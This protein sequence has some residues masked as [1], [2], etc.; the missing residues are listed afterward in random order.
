MAHGMNVKR[1]TMTYYDRK[2]RLPHGAVSAIAKDAGC[3]VSLVSMVLRGTRRNLGVEAR[4]AAAMRPRVTPAY[5]F[6][7]SK[8][9]DWKAA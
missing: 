3:A 1:G 6:G 8:L 4:L 5:A 9:R 7:P 2:A